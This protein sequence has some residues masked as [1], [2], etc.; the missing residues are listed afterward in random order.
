MGV[1]S[2]KSSITPRK[3]HSTKR[4]SPS[5]VMKVVKAGTKFA[6]T[7]GAEVI[8]DVAST[9]V[10]ISRATAKA[11]GVLLGELVEVSSVKKVPRTKNEQ[12]YR[13]QVR[14]SKCGGGK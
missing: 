8:R 11:S 12:E 2:A 1:S 9:A 13:R 4:D 3:N 5:K 14:M 6:K 10:D 7:V